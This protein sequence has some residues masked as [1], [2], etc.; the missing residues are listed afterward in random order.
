MYFLLLPLLLSTGLSAVSSVSE[1]TTPYT[2]EMT[3]FLQQILFVPFF[4][5]KRVKYLRYGMEH[6]WE[7]EEYAGKSIS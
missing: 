1:E 6:E 3:R 7:N 2:P 4:P 5:G